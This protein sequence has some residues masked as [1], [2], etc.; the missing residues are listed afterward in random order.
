MSSWNF[1]GV[2]FENMLEEPSWAFS[3]LFLNNNSEFIL[4]A[5]KEE[6]KEFETI[7]LDNMYDGDDE[8][9][10]SESNESDLEDL[11]F[12]PEQETV[13]LDNMY[14]GDDDGSNSES[15]SDPN[16]ASTSDLL[17]LLQHEEQ[18][19]Q[20]QEQ[21]RN[22]PKPAH[23]SKPPNSLRNRSD[24]PRG[25]SLDL[26]SPTPRF[27][28]SS[29]IRKTV[30][31]IGNT[32][33]ITQ[34]GKESA[35]RI[36]EAPRRKKRV[37]V[38]S[39]RVDVPCRPI[40]D[41]TKGF[42]PNDSEKTDNEFVPNML[43]GF[44][45]MNIGALRQD[46][47]T[48]EIVH[49][50]EAQEFRCD[51]EKPEKFSMEPHWFHDTK[52]KRCWCIHCIQYRKTQSTGEQMEAHD[53]NYYC[54]CAS[55]SKLYHKTVPEGQYCNCHNCAD[56]DVKEDECLTDQDEAF[57]KLQEQIQLQSSEGR[58]RDSEQIVTETSQKL[59]SDLLCE[60]SITVASESNGGPSEFLSMIRENLWLNS[61]SSTVGDFNEEQTF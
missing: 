14:D 20:A 56:A 18:Q 12:Q 36:L 43:E 45:T 13:P 35:P 46:Y 21:E 29:P 57:A 22:P 42:P 50:T 3:H 52:Y 15:N 44:E 10:N 7:P 8:D 49:P 11:L 55:C 53:F 23:A 39:L 25:Y 31:L 9:S 47:E 24:Y 40:T 38:S 26:Q 16:S 41:S 51:M 33:E 59:P 37:P 17:L 6:E 54:L 32:H 2:D 27:N 34:K 48:G 61:D 58:I 19:E 4:E 28:T 1:T 30:F 5:P 60:E